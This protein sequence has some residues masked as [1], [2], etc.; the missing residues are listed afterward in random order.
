MTDAEVLFYH[1]ERTTLEK[2]L[3]GLLEKSLERKWKALVLAGTEAKTASLDTH[4][5]TYR[6]ESF[7][8]HAVMGQSTDGAQEPV[9][10]SSDGAAV[11]APDNK[12]NI[13]FLVDGATAPPEQLKAYTRTVVIFDGRNSEA[14]EG[15][16]GFWK[17]IKE[18]GAEL[19]LTYWQQG[20][21]GRWEKKA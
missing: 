18:I 20:D 2:V 16:R 14:L 19:S 7:L 5:W 9:L 8:P 21:G 13:L 12:A 4:L 15:A 17:Q 1:L 3:P 11:A 6:E 10:L